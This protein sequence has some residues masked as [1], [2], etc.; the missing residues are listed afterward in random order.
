M[1]TRS[2]RTVA[3]LV[4]GLS[5]IVIFA[6]ALAVARAPDDG[7]LAQGLRGGGF[8]I[9]VRHGPTF[10][11]IDDGDLLN[12]DS[13]AAQLNLNDEGETLAKAFGRAMHDVGIP[14]GR[15]FTS[16]YNGSYETAVLAGFEDIVKV[17]DLTDGGLV[18]SP[19]EYDRRAEGFRKMIAMPPNTGTNTILITHQRNLVAALGK[20]WQDV[21]QG[22]ASIFRPENGTYKLVARVQID[23]WRRIANAAKAPTRPL[24]EI[25]QQPTAQPH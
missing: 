15:V 21:K 25:P 7:A 12:L 13:N 23:E 2:R 10:A 17:S 3:A 11:D 6:V 14:V 22:E 1:K 9:V 8:V 5:L 18:I 20:G 16:K 24:A 4:A 19:R